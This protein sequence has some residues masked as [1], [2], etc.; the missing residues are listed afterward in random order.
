M[1]HR[2]NQS[3]TRSDGHSRG[4][5]AEPMPTWNPIRVTHSTGQATDHGAPLP[6]QAAGSQGQILICERHRAI[7][8]LTGWMAPSVAYRPPD[9]LLGLRQLSHTSEAASQ[10]LCAA[11]KQLSAAQ[12][13]SR[14]QTV[15][16]SV[17]YD[18][19]AR[20]PPQPQGPL[21]AAAAAAAGEGPPDLPWPACV[22]FAGPGG[23][24]RSSCVLQSATAIAG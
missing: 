18:R 14:V 3:R 10:Q 7:T 24:C 21:P 8:S 15:D 20:R 13:Q 11:A 6:L 2:T 5:P 12:R 19:G 22:V 9:S 16:A 17:S 1:A 23:W 4:Q